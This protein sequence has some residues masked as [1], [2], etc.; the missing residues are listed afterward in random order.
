MCSMPG[1]RYCG[2]DTGHILINLP[3]RQFVFSIKKRRGGGAAAQNERFIAVALK[4]WCAYII[5]LLIFV[6]SCDNGHLPSTLFIDCMAYHK[7]LQISAKQNNEMCWLTSTSKPQRNRIFFRSEIN[8]QNNN[9]ITSLNAQL[10]LLSHAHKHYESS[11]CNNFTAFAMYT[12]RK[13]THARRR[14]P[15]HVYYFQS[16]LK[17][18]SSLNSFIPGTI[19]RK[20]PLFNGLKIKFK[21]IC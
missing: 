21:N 4:K 19:L 1:Y 15:V 5:L 11:C 17:I 8:K 16:L 7:L 6:H 20:E 18:K 3:V 14:Y 12:Q 13:R 2:V 10:S 9:R